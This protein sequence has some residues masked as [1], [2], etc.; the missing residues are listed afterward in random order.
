MG[1]IHHTE[2]KWA[3][4]LDICRLYVGTS[5]KTKWKKNTYDGEYWLEALACE[6]KS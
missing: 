4:N 6:I 5:M 3:S 2:T 1:N